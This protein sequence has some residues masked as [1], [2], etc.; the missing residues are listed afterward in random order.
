[1]GIAPDHWQEGNH[2]I[3]HLRRRLSDQELAGLPADWVA[4]PAIDPG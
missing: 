1:V 3:L 2:G 4:L